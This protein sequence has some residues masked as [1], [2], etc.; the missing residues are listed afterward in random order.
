MT[1][2][3]YNIKNYETDHTTF[4]GLIYSSDFN[5]DYRGKNNTKGSPIANRI[6]S[7]RQ[8]DKQCK[9]NREE[10]ERNKQYCK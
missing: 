6:A 4:G 9:K 10:N 8:F 5:T 3:I 7:D 1:E 2:R